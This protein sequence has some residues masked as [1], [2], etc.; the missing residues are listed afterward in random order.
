MELEFDSLMS[1]WEDSQALER[2]QNRA[3]FYGFM[4]ERGF[5][6]EDVDE[7]TRLPKSLEPVLEGDADDL[8]KFNAAL[9]DIHKKK[10]INI[11]DAVIYLTSDY[12]EEKTMLKLLDEM[13]HYLLSQELLKRYHIKQEESE[14]SLM[15]FFENAD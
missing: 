12:F 13:N 8:H 15:D 4:K 3:S 14:T 11:S 1:D 2:K 6:F 5:D 9:H 10:L 7:T